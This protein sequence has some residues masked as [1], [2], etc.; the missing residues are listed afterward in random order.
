[1]AE[2][3]DFENVRISN[4]QR[5]VTLTLDQA[6]WHTVMRHSWTSTHTPHFIRI[7]ETFCGRTYVPTDK[8]IDIDVGSIRSTQWS[9]AKNPHLKHLAQLP[10]EITSVFKLLFHKA[11][12]Q[13][14]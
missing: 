4:F 10:C 13:D 6:I 5:H 7:G 3:I 14:V 2:E 12:Q 8:W 1:M 9:R 11:V